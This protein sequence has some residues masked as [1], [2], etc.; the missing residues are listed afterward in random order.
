MSAF[1][2]IIDLLFPSGEPAVE[3]SQLIDRGLEAL[4]SAR[5]ARK[6]VMGSSKRVPGRLELRMP[7]GLFD[8]LA[9]VGG[10]RDVEFFLNDELMKD[11]RIDGMKT[12]GDAPVHVSVAVDST[13][14]PNEIFACVVSADDEDVGSGD[15]L[16]ARTMVL[17]VDDVAPRH[18]VDN[19]A[20]R[21]RLVIRRG[22]RLVADILLEGRHWIVGRRGS[23][24]RPVPDGCRKIDVDFEPTVSREQIR[25][26]MIDDDRFRLQRVGHGAV[27]LG[28][29]ESLASDENRLVAVG[30]PFSI[31]DYEVTLVRGRG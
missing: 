5:D 12:F 25:L 11:L 22:G 14:A 3:R 30:V 2:R 19:V 27:V 17:G 29:G 13:L 21:H 7:Q 8:E 26:D 18:A 6:I 16:E 1:R 20:P 24:G 15:P 28:D 9:L 23:G 10:V 31:E 4:R